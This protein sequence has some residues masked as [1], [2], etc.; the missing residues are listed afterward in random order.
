MLNLRRLG[1]YKKFR[2]DRDAMP[3]GYRDKQATAQ[4]GAKLE[5]ESELAQ[6]GIVD[7]FKEHGKRPL[8]E[9]L[10]SISLV[11]AAC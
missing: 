7:R 10:V 4:S 3:K 9:Q 8:K 2:P 6:G 1:R 11:K 5:K